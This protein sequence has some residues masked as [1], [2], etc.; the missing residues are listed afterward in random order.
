MKKILLPTDFSENSWNAIK[1]ALQL[2]KNETCKFYILNVY[3]PV[4]YDV[5]F[6][7]VSP[8]QFGMVDAVKEAAL[9]HLKD[10][11][12]RIKRE[13]KNPKHSIKTMLQFN[14]LISEMEDIVEDQAIDY[15]V[16]GTQG[17]TG[18]KE[19]LF[20]S[21]TVHVFNKIK[22]P[23]IAI[24]E[25]FEFEQPHEILFPTDYEIDY[26]KKLL[27]PLIHLTSLYISRVNVLNVSF[28]YELTEYQENNKKVLETF[29][30]KTAHLFHSVSNETVQEAITSFQQRARINLLVMI[31]NKHSFFENLFFRSTINQIGFH[32]NIPFLLIPT[33]TIKP[34]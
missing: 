23:V 12:E 17:A 10:L 33:K 3:T 1:Y 8:A 13:F 25:N 6:V 2:F 20:G 28:G 16:M 22:C 29:L 24:P 18:A 34:K 31:N 15:V 7:L 9:K 11:E 19:V 4:V 5:E 21:N 14:T 30:N 32:L 27:K 26:T